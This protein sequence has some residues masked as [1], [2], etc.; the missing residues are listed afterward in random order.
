MRNEEILDEFGRKIASIFDDAS[1][2]VLKDLGRIDNPEVLADFAF[3]N[4]MQRYTG[5][6][7]ILK[8]VQ[9]GLIQFIHGFLVYLDESRN[10][11]LIIDNDGKYVDLKKI[12]DEFPPE[13]FGW[14]ENYS[15]YDDFTRLISVEFDRLWDAQKG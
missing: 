13:I 5:N 9:Y 8:F 10:V 7:K 4:V 6:D 3:R 2:I 1:D 12:P 11:K 14:I 15:K